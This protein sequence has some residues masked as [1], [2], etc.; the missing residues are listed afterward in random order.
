MNVRFEPVRLATGSEE[1]GML[2]FLDEKLIAILVHLA[3]DNSVAPGHW[4]LEASFDGLPGLS[5]PT[6][7]DLDA[8]ERWVVMSMSSSSRRW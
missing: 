4:F 8:A 1:E 3:P 7:P 6:F 2:V 5:A